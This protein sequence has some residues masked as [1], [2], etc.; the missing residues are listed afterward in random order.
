MIIEIPKDRGGFPSLEDSP[1][2]EFERRM[3]ERTIIDPVTHCWLYTGHLL[4]GYGQITVN[5]IIQYT[6]RISATIYL[7][8]N[9]LDKDHDVLHKLECLNRNC[10]QPQHLYI[11]TNSDNIADKME[12][13]NARNQ[14]YYATHCIN[15]HEFTPEN[16]RIRKNG[17]R[18]CKQCERDRYEVNK[19]VK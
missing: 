4:K 19:G 10:W 7:E 2:I 15:G 11:G 5:G 18:T 16:T 14:Y 13:E 17:G 9:L 8:Y 1:W 12:M 3:R 6:H